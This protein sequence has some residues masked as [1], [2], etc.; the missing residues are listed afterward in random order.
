KAVPTASRPLVSRSQ[1][2]D[3][4]AAHDGSEPPRVP[5]P[6]SARG[7]GGRHFGPDWGTEAARAARA[8][9]A[10]REPC[11]LARATNRRALRGTEPQLGRSRAAQPGLAPAQGPRPGGCGRAA[12]RSP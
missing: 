9:P 10:E 11:R 12:A 2:E 1:V 5:D 7:S 3:T 6:R 8:A 4:L